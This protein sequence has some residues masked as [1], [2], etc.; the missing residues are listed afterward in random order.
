M[1]ELNDS[2]FLDPN[3]NFELVMY[4][5]RQRIERLQLDML[6][7]HDEELKGVAVKIYTKLRLEYFDMIKKDLE[8]HKMYE[9]YEEEEEDV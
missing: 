8:L 3:H 7:I 5:L 6:N 2:E 4:E 9:G 1:T